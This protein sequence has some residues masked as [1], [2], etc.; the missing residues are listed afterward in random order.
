[1]RVLSCEQYDA[2][3]GTC[4]SEVWVEQM[5]L[6]PP[7]PIADATVIVSAIITT[8]ASAWALKAVRRFIW[9]RA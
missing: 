9:P 8:C 3:T 4:T 6:L 7:L 2:A 1:M 5:G